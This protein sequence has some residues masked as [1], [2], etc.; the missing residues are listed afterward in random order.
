M[1]RDHY[2]QL[3]KQALTADGWTITDDPLYLDLA[4]TT[5]EVDLGAERLIAAEKGKEKI[6][7]EIKS[8]LGNS[9]VSEFYKAMGQFNFY[10]L[11]LEELEP[12]RLLYLAMPEPAYQDV[13]KE[14]IAQK[15]IERYR[16]R[17]IVYSLEQQIITSW[18]G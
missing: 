5:L 4:S 14:P 7:V 12:E 6:A 2:H 1:A 11:A 15:A 3:V 10:N 17:F 13:R 16:I 9:T 8:F 18:I